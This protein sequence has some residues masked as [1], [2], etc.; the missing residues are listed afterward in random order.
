L[1]LKS[2]DPQDTP[3]IN[4]NYFAQGA[5]E[6]LTALQEAAEFARRFLRGTQNDTGLT[7]FKELHP[8]AGTKGCSVHDQKEYLRSQVYGHHATGTC[9]M[10]IKSDPLAVVDNEFKVYGV[11]NLR[12]V[13][14]S[15]S[16]E[17]MG[18]FPVLATYMFSG[19]ARDSILDRL[20]QEKKKAT[21]A[22]PK[23][24]PDGP[25]PGPLP[26]PTHPQPPRPPKHPL[27]GLLPGPPPN[28][29]KP[30]PKWPWRK[31]RERWLP[32]P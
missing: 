9:K 19:K 16:P 20:T 3:D 23:Q 26:G 29:H 18:P 13:D 11:E 32:V 5:D 22:A 8:C 6:D 2:A 17:P 14:A 1:R 7:P 27:P 31:P 28:P 24:H 10:G 12:V 25:L 30:K 4:M 21:P 15:V